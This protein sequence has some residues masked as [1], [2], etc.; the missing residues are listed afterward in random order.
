MKKK[1][2]LKQENT[3]KRT[4]RITC[5]ISDREDEI[6][7]NYLA[8]YN[9]KNKSTWLRETVLHFIYDRTENDYP[10]LFNDH[11]MRR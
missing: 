6:I 11:E 1:I 4:K 7:N 5:L 3:S 8:R 9:I 2:N 10:T